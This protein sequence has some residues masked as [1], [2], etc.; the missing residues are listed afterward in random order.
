MSDSP[1]TLATREEP[2]IAIMLQAAFE[3]GITGDSVA[4][5][6]RLMGLYE[7]NQDR[8]AERDFASAFVGLQREM[9]KV[10]A[11]KAVNNSVAKGG[12]LRYMF[13]PFDE[14]MRAIQPALVAN[15][16]AITFDS[17]VEEGG[18]MASVCT[19]M[20]ISGHS[21]SNTFSCRIG[22]G[23]PGS[24]E[25]QADGSASSYAK[26]FALCNA[27]NIVVEGIDDDA[28]LQGE[29][30]DAETSDAL[31]QRVALL[32]KKT[33]F[34][35]STFFKLAGAST[36]E[37]IPQGKYD[38]LDETLFALEKTAKIRDAK[39]EWLV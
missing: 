37:K 6:E 16:F 22:Q 35:E 3:K 14:I 5:V 13:A 1:T 10:K 9:Q 24:N 7:R 20:H 21:R 8:Q 32:K 29:P 4:A 12:G 26:R 15:G 34:D 11:T 17:K 2:S 23:P 25:S 38:L 18:R 30:I 27:L 28:R 19:L 36:Y 33:N 39:G 31:C